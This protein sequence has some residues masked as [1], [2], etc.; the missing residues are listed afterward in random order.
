MSVSA[1]DFRKTEAKNDVGKKKYAKAVAAGRLP[2]P[3]NTREALNA[4]DAE[5]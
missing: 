1:S 5:Q 2:D 4:P 3:M